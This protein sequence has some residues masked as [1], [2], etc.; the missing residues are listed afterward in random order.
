MQS[1]ILFV[2]GAPRRESAM[3][4]AAVRGSAG[5]RQA[6]R[7]ARQVPSVLSFLRGC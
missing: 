2:A 4:A 7:A 3:F 1:E 5:Q 6:E